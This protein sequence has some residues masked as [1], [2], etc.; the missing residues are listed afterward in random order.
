MDNEKEDE[1]KL[2]KYHDMFL[3]YAAEE[4]RLLSSIDFAVSSF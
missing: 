4:W 3:S 1:E 2:K